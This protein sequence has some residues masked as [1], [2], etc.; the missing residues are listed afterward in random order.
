ML[1]NALHGYQ[2]LQDYGRLCYPTAGTIGVN[3][4]G[5]VKVWVNENW[6]LN[7]AKGKPPHESLVIEELINLVE[8]R[9]ER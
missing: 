7:K 4:K 3:R 1:I 6:A 2:Q 5:Q 8:E 9:M